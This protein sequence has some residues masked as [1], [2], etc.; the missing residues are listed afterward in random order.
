VDPISK[1]PRVRSCSANMY[2]GPNS[3]NYLFGTYGLDSNYRPF[4][5]YTDFGAGFG[6]QDCFV[7]LDENPGSLNDGYFEFVANPSPLKINDRPA[8]NHGNTSA[9]SFADGH[10]ERHKWANTYLNLKNTVA[11][12]DVQWISQ[13]GTIHK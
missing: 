9:F 12:S 11:G 5:K 10:C 13:H 7:Y 8:V 3:R 1:A 4:Y 2:C 6:T